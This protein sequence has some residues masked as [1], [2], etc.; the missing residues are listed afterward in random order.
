[1]QTEAP[2]P[3]EDWEPGCCALCGATSGVSAADRS[4]AFGIRNQLCWSCAVSRG[5]VYDEERDCWDRKPDL[6]DLPDE[7]YGTSPHEVRRG[8]PRG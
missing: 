3:S 5:G 2:E 6:S 4:Y 8:R 7:A 1:M